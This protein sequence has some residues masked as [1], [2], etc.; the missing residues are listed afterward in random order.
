SA[1]SRLRI[2]TASASAREY[3]HLNYGALE[4]TTV[5]HGVET[6]HENVGILAISQPEAYEWIYENVGFIV[7]RRD[8]G[9]EYIYEGDVSTN[10]PVPHVWFVWREY[11]FV[12]DHIFVYGQ[13]FGTLQ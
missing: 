1:P 8:A 2:Y 11:G 13:G 9:V 3:V 12:E 4:G 7:T 6:I 5:A 10:V